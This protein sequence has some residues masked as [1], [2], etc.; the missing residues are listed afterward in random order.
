MKWRAE[1]F[2]ALR[3]NP[4]PV[5]AIAG[6]HDAL[7]PVQAARDIHARAPRAR[8]EIVAG[9]GHLVNVEAPE[10]FDALVTAFAASL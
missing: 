8:L 4:L 6:E 5:L 2:G 7:V 1:G 3:A 10:R 9:A